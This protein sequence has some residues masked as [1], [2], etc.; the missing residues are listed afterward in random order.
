VKP[1]CPRCDRVHASDMAYAVGRFTGDVTYQAA[2]AGTPP[3]RTRAEA[4]DDECRHKA[5]PTDEE[6]P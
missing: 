5:P 6:E 4:E 1:P 2:T 3:R